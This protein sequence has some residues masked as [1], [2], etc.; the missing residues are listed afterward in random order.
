M[1]N[2]VTFTSSNELHP[3]E[4]LVIVH[5]NTYVT[6]GVPVKLVVGFV[7]LKKL[8]PVPLTIL[9]T[10]VWFGPIVPAFNPI[11]ETPQSVDMSAP[12]SA[13]FA[14]R[15]NVIITVSALSQIPLIVLHS[16]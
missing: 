9:Q 15:G 11:V 7:A 10:P 2:I 8:P 3:E 4:V 12:A 14:F 6:P 16:N 13:R 1:G 5:L